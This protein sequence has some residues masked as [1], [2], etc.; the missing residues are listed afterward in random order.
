MSAPREDRLG[1]FVPFARAYG[2]ADPT[3]RAQVD[4]AGASY[5]ARLITEGEYVKR[6]ALLL[7]VPIPQR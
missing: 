7:D 2:A 1:V 6:V 4:A 3:L 5:S